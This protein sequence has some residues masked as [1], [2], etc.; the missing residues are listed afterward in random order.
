M[1]RLALF[2]LFP[3]VIASVV[4]TDA[5]EI[6]IRHDRPDSA[7]RALGERYADVLAHIDNRVEGIVLRP[8]WILTA[9][10]AVQTIGPFDEPFATINGERF[11]IEKIITHPEWEGNWNDLL[12]NHDLALLKL[13]RPLSRVRQIAL[14][15]GRDEQGKVVTIL[16]RGKTGTGATGQV[17]GKG[18]IVRGATNRIDG[19]SETALL[20][21][22]DNLD[23]TE[24]EGA[25]GAGD[26]GGPA[27][28]ER[29]DTLFVLGVSSAGTAPTGYSAYGALDIYTRV[30]TFANWIERTIATDPPSTVD[31][32]RPVRFGNSPRWPDSPVGRLARDFFT[33]IRGDSASLDAF[34]R[35]HGADTDHAGWAKRVRGGLVDTFGPLQLHSFATAGPTMIQVLVYSPKRDVW[36]SI[37]LNTTADSAHKLDRLYLKDE[38]PPR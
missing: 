3:L 11:G 14:Y 2:S 13:E 31:W 26:S 1:Q 35:K 22:F 24:L 28:M 4:P 5:P 34:H 21:V 15:R 18:T 29:G 32:S 38:A 30:S 17:G 7:Y 36:R 33:A 9:A 16:G 27:L 12:R 37:G 10:H 19:A 8:R 20:F 6:L 23:P 25:G